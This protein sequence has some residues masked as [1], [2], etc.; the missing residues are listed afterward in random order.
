MQQ[1]KHIRVPK[2]LTPQECWAHALTVK[3]NMMFKSRISNYIR[4]GEG[5]V[6]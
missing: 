3:D 1:Q 2:D 5:D 4:V 6:A